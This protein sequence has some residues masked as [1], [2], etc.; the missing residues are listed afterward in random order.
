MIETPVSINVRGG[1]DNLVQERSVGRGLWGTARAGAP[2]CAWRRRRRAGRRGRVSGRRAGLQ[3]RDQQT[4]ADEQADGAGNVRD[5]GRA[6]L[7][8]R[9]AAAPAALARNVA[10]PVCG[11]VIPKGRYSIVV[12]VWPLHVGML[13]DLSYKHS[14]PP[15]R[16]LAYQEPTM[17]GSSACTAPARIA[18]V[19]APIPTAAI[20][21]AAAAD[22][23]APA[24]PLVR[25]P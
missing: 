14:C 11:H 4:G 1:G 18:P 7:A 21:A 10:P 8:A 12:P 20:P 22:A 19:A 3:E 2:A 17:P 9:R 15:C 6:G 24:P 23:P 16:F 5:D 25:S 13:A